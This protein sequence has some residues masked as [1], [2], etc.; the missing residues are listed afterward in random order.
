M[1]QYAAEIKRYDPDYE[2]EVV[3]AS[4]D[5]AAEWLLAQQKYGRCR[6][7]INNERVRI[8]QGRIVSDEPAHKLD[9]MGTVVNQ[10]I[11]ALR[12]S[13]LEPMLVSKE[14]L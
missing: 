9:D 13:E 4:R 12:G 1:K 10:I 6:M 3:F 8:Q 7:W 2:E 11:A 5:E 14:A